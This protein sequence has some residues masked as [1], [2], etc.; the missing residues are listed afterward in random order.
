MT[1]KDRLAGCIIGG[2]IGDAW[3]SAFENLPSR[4][5]V[6][7]Y[8]LGD[9]RES[10]PSWSFTDDTQ[11]T[12]ITLE[13]VF[14]AD[15]LTPEMLAGIFVQYYK[16]GKITGVGASTLKAL[17]ELA[18]G[19]HWSQAGRTGEYAAGNGA[20]MRIAPFAF[21]DDYTREEI[22]NFCRIT[23]RNEEAY[24]AALAVVVS[25]QQILQNNWNGENGLIDLVVPLL[26]DTNVRDRLIEL[27]RLS[28]ENSIAEAA[29]LGTSG[30][31][32]HSI[33]F[34]VFCASQVK[35]VGMEN[36]YQQ[37]IDSGGDTDT[38]ASLAGQIA[39]ALLGEAHIPVKLINKLKAVHGFQWLNSVVN[40]VKVKLR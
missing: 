13:A 4:K 29:T 5:E 12:L 32:A 16:R 19:G 22:R 21:K 15:K 34:A 26:P 14:R 1:I 7:T 33:P 2:A 6:T 37:I 31:C 27:N 18:A 10:R 24:V 8:Y 36:M 28:V 11:L 25:L 38:N 23:H 35:R 9:V 39:G 30:Y 3:G 40:E 20:A 17:Q